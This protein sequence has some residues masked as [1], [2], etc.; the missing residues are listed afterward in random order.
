MKFKDWIRL[1]EIQ[2]ILLPNYVDVNGITTDGL[3]FRFEDWNKGYNPKKQKN[4]KMMPSGNK[5]FD[6]SM[7][8]V[9]LNDGKFI[10]IN[11]N[12]SFSDNEIIGNLALKTK[13]RTVINVEN[14]ALYD[15]LPYQWFDFAIM[16]LKHKVVKSPEW[17]RGDHELVTNTTIEDPISSK[18]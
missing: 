6:A 9:P 16:Y 18:L 2:H 17:P 12:A 7:F 3:D 13:K 1:D 4:A 11:H 5:F 10:N 15:K 8:S 14:E